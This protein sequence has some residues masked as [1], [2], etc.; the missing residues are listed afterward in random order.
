MRPGA[1]R[2]V[3][4]S[5]LARAGAAAA[6]SCALLGCGRPSGTVEGTA[7]IEGAPAAGAEIQ[8]FLKAGAERS[9]EPFAS[10]SAGGDGAYRLTLP[11]GSYHVVA[12]KTVGDT[13]RARIYKGE[14]PGNPVVVNRGG[15]LAGIDVPLVEMSSGG[16][17]PRP[18]TGVTGRVSS[19]GEAARDIWVYAYPSGAGTVR[20]PSYAA[21]ARTDDAGRFRLALREGTFL[22]VARRKGGADE[23]GAMGPGGRNGEG[24]GKAVSL[25]PGETRDIGEI[26]LHAPREESR[27]LRAGSGG[28]ERAAAE[29]RGAVVR[30]GG[31]PGNGVHVMAYADRR[32]IGRPYAISGR[33]G[34]DGTFV[35]FLPRAGT[36]YLGAR[37]GRGGPVSPGEWV[38]TYDEAPDHAVTV[39]SGERLDGLRIRVVEKWCGVG[40]RLREGARAAPRR[41]RSRSRCFLR[42][43]PHRRPAPRSGRSSGAGRSPATLLF[44]RG[45]PGRCGRGRRSGSA[46]GSGRFA[47]GSWWKGRPPT[48]SASPETTRS[49]GSTSAD[50]TDRS[51]RTP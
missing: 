28:Q 16:F 49:R 39:R 1:G 11:P 22:V 3:R 6:L 8:V 32:M 35:L 18:G 31:A 27:R 4:A 23:T 17:A 48:R 12:R 41:P 26:A 2:R 37:T 40:A 30:E 51:W 14:F 42:P 29:V 45:T 47:A 19:G 24:D 38:G 15:R 20:G 7:A 9:G 5:A 25:G 13:G 44:R 50:R 36:F 33:T 34:K 10:G 46:G 43:A 21:F